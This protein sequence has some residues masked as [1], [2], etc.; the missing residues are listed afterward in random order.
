[1]SN[2]ALTN[3]KYMVDQDSS[4]TFDSPVMDLTM[5]NTAIGYHFKWDAGVRGVLTWY[6]SIFEDDYEWEQYVAC[7]PVEYTI[8]GSATSTIITLPSNWM[9]VGHLKFSWVPDVG[10]STGNISTAIRIVPI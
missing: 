3:L 7:E 2:K 9:M 4:V 10:G 1:M 8:D 6:A 5:P